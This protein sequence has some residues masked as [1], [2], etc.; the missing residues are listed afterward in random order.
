MFEKEG[1][2]QID[3]CRSM[4]ELF[5]PQTSAVFTYISLGRI[6]YREKLQAY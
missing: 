6:R 2:D 5:L 1:T 4:Q 3:Q